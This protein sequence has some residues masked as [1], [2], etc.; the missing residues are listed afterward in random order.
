MES[1]ASRVDFSDADV[2][3]VSILRPARKGHRQENVFAKAEEIVGDYRFVPASNCRD[4]QLMKQTL[5][6]DRNS[7]RIT[8]L[9]VL[10]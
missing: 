8:Y 6:G 4:Y 2:S 9:C 7:L 1:T 3:D 10:N 5:N